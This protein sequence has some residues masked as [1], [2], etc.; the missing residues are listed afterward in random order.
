MSRPFI[1]AVVVLVL[2]C[3]I[4]NVAAAVRTEDATRPRGELK[5]LYFGEALFEAYQG[6][7]FDAISRL[8]T[9]LIQ[10]YGLDEPKL[11]SLYYHIDNAE[12][13]VGDFELY[14]RMHNRAGRAITA[15]IEGNVEE[16]VRN[17]AI[18]R[19][20]RIYYQ[21][22]QPQDA[23]STIEKLVGAVPEQLRYEEPFLRSQIY[24]ENGMYAKA[25]ELLKGIQNAEGLEAYAGYN[26]GVAYF[27]SGMETE[28]IAQL[29]RVGQ[30][31]SAD[32]R[33]LA[34]RDKANLVLGFKL[35][36]A[37][38]PEQ[39]KQYLQ[40]VRI[41]G[42]FSNKALLGVG[43]AMAATEM[44]D[45]ALVPWTM[46]SQRNITD[47][48]VQE[49]LLGVPYAYKKLDIHGRAALLYGQALDA[50]GKEIKRLDASIASIREGRFLEAVIREELK[51]DKNWL[52]NLRALPDT[53]ETYY[54]AQMMA[55]HDFQES[56]K[57]YYDLTDLDKRLARW[58][59]YLDAYEDI[60]RVRRAYYEPMLTDI[61]A[62]FR[63]LDSKMKLRIEQ[64]ETLEKR[65][66]KMLVSPR[67]D[68][69]ATADERILL[70]RIS[71]LRQRLDK[72]GV[73]DEMLRH[74]LDRLQGMITWPIDI[75]YYERFA[76][77]AENLRQLDDHVEELKG[78][79]ESFVRTRQA[80]TQSY[81]GYD[82]LLQ[83]L[84]I[85]IKAA[86]EKVD[87]LITRQGHLINVMAINELEL[88]HQRLEEYEVKAR[89]AM[90]ESYDRATKEK[91]KRYEEEIRQR[92]ELQ[93]MK[94]SGQP[95]Q[96][97]ESV[98]R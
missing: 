81:R 66:Q 64:R 65:L 97:A 13:S 25:I 33:M 44:F 7:Y 70:Q 18:Y 72:Q 16:K 27:L 92:Q 79:Y 78:I 41:E 77:A 31:D 45:R 80:A 90:A 57:N 55:S 96:K 11:N 67:P 30:L 9:E 2:L 95:E 85:K 46:L 54:L 82:E 38:K 51:T 23:L 3:N 29:A 61:E 68:F 73:S 69:L 26:L 93:D 40:R 89:F 10:Y 12:F 84:R 53:P 8:D 63:T 42:P 28:G 76:H 43:W 24:M 60:I 36:K 15:V 20:A 5:D 21:K 14:Y 47:K 50:Y 39:A 75:E 87:Q 32:E 88:R 4:V 94:Q 52:I 71:T 98:S 1:S 56:L 74:R 58:A 91:Q 19:L 86:Q 59:D 49:V 37:D 34:M 22:Q 48:T 6:N 35:L 17:E 83:G 62:R